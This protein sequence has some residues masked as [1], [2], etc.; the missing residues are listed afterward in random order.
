MLLLI[1]IGWKVPG[2]IAGIMRKSCNAGNPPSGGF[3]GGF[4]G[5]EVVEWEYGSL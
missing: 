3:F 5:G 2:I 4:F 1:G